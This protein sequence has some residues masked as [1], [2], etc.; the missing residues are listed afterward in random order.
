M[1][2]VT[3]TTTKSRQKG[4]APLKEITYLSVKV[5]GAVIQRR[6]IMT[7]DDQDYRIYPKEDKPFTKQK[8]YLDKLMENEEFKEKFVKEYKNL[9]RPLKKK[10]LPKSD[11]N[12]EIIPGEK[13]TDEFINNLVSDFYKNKNHN[14]KKKIINA[15][16][17]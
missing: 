17:P 3:I 12:W 14:T 8:T 11:E 9:D 13:L 7:I 16:Q 1:G 2:Y 5:G 15:D 6:L 4:P 10:Q